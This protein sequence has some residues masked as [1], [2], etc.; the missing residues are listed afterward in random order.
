MEEKKEFKSDTVTFTMERKPDCIVE[1][2]VKVSPEI[3]Q[4]ARREAIRSIAKEVSLPGFRKGKAP[5][6]L[7]VKKFPDALKERWQKSIADTAFRECQEVAKIPILS[8]DA[9]ITFNVDKQ[10]VEE[11]AELTYSF[12][13]EPEVPEIDI[14]KLELAKEERDTIDGK[15]VDETIDQIRH[16]FA[17]WE[18]VSDRAVEKEDYVVVDVDVI[19]E[20]P[21]RKALTNTRFQVNREKMAKWMFDLVLGMKI[22]DAK[23]GVSVPDEDAPEEHKEENPPK[24]VRLTLRTIEKALLPAIDDELAKKVG[25]ATEKEMRENLEKL[26]NNQADDH[27]QKAYRDQV[28]EYLIENCQFDLPKT[29]LQKETQFRIKQLVSDPEF[30]RK[31]MGMDE[32]ERKDAIQ[33]I[34]RQGERA[35]RLFYIARKVIQDQNIQISPT[36]VHQEVKTPLEAMFSD[37]SDLYTAKEQSQEQRAIA[38]SR[39]VLVKA[40]DYL[41]SQAKIGAPKPKKKAAAKPKK[42]EKPKTDKPKTEKKEEKKAPPKKKTAAPKKAA[43]AAPKKAAP[44]KKAAQKKKTDKS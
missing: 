9:Q 24:K 21:P 36:E 34:E 18:K 43:K 20:D 28:N 23:E 29:L 3:V 42:E 44:K 30:Q 32:E 25:V 16:Y 8:Q 40:E 12:E 15:K 5:D 10:S 11:G 27:V 13:T 19:E 6:A 33:D 17:E 26:L 22:G 35:V 14:E 4:K 41:I 1:Y 39:L 2:K 37:Q 7:I 31:L 38:M